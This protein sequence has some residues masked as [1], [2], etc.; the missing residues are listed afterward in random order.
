MRFDYKNTIMVAGHRG[1]PD[2]YPENTIQSFMSAI[3]KGVDMIETDIHMSKDGVLVLIH[4]SSVD[5]TTDGTGYVKDKTYEELY[6]LNAGTAD[7]FQH[8]PTLEEFLKLVVQNDV[9]INLEFKDYYD[10]SNAEFCHEAVGKTIALVE[11][12]NL[13]SKCVLNSF[14]A[15][16]LEYID[17]KYNGKYRLHGFYPYNIMKNVVRNPDEYLYCACVFDDRNRENYEYLRNR[18]IEVWLGAGI[19]EKEDF[20]RAVKLGGILFTSNNPG[21]AIQILEELG[22]RKELKWVIQTI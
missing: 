18:N 19:K 1:D 15:F 16:I 11:K 21:K 20:E 3:E 5:R 22:L 12:Y 4:D 14:D 13:A 8:I 2:N 17:Q 7:N 10:D 9:L 6:E